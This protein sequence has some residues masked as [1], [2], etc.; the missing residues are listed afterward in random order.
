MNDKRFPQLIDLVVKE[1]VLIE[2][3]KR[4][5]AAVFGGEIGGYLFTLL[6]IGGFIWGFIFLFKAM[7]LYAFATLIGIILLLI[8]WWIIA[9]NYFSIR[10]G[11]DYDFFRKAYERKVIRLR[12]KDSDILV[13]S[14]EPWH[15]IFT[16]VKTSENPSKKE[17][18]ANQ[19]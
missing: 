13:E 6:F 11:R 7:F 9:F 17:M 15:T 16:A 1:K 5:S 12:V 3:S 10:S 8:I 4:Y 14:P 19:S 2:I 18:K